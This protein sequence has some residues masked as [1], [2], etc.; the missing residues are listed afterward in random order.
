MR[1]ADN[2]AENFSFFSDQIGGSENFLPDLENFSTSTGYLIV[3]LGPKI[4]CRLFQFFSVFHKNPYCNNHTSTPHN[5]I[6]NIMAQIQMKGKCSLPRVAS[7]LLL[8]L[9]IVVRSLLL[10]L[11]GPRFYVGYSSCWGTTSVCFNGRRRRSFCT[12]VRQH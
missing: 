11:C 4:W 8:L 2:L 9:W 1:N 7:L 12:T 3:K 6:Q 5:N 10:F